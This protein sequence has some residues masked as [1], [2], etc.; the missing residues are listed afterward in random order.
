MH[1]AVTDRERRGQS[2]AFEQFPDADDRI[3]LLAGNE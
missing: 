3:L 2:G 1:D